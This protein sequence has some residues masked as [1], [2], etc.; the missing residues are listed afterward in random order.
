MKKICKCYTSYTLGPLP[1]SQTVTTSRIPLEGDA[2][3]GRSL[4]SLVKYAQSLEDKI[5]LSSS[6]GVRTPTIE[7]NP[8]VSRRIRRI[9]IG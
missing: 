4:I 9:W 7:T 6:S 3:Y 8:S 1:V 5:L 2:L